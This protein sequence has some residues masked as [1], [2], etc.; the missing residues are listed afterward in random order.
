MRLH[1]P[2]PSNRQKSP[3]RQTDGFKSLTAIRENAI[4]NL[5]QIERGFHDVNVAWGPFSFAVQ[6]SCFIIAS[7]QPAHYDRANL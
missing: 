2:S 7:D 6:V 4:L 3:A 5:L 1:C